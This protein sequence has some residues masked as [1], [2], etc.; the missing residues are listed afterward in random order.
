MTANTIT[1]SRILLSA[2]LL[3]LPPDSAAFGTVYILCGLSD[4]ADGFTAR[5]THTESEKGARLDSIAD[6]VFVA[7]CAAKLL[8]HMRLN[9]W[10]WIWAGIIAL[11][12]LINLASGYVKCGKA[13]M[14]HTRANKLTGLMLFLMPA[15]M[16]IVN[17]T[18][19]VVAVC[20]AA[21]FAAIQEG[22]LIWKD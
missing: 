9:L 21:S 13:V 6:A 14:P 1:Y 22:H 15:A 2:G 17:I 11:I 12:K 10:L 16:Q 7:V 3:F 18:Y 19:P 5:K 8:P 4:M 20:A